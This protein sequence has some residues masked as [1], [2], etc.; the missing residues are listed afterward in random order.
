MIDYDVVYAKAGNIRNC[1]RRIRE[2]THLEADRLVDIDVQDIFVLN[3]QR[4]IQSAI[5]LAAHLVAAEGLG[6]PG[7][8]RENFTLLQRA[9]IITPQIASEMTKMVGFRNIAIHEYQNLDVDVLKS[10]L[11]QHLQD[12]EEFTHH[13]LVHYKL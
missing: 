12:L 13:I 1:L 5:D 9:N 11:T 7:S 3:L 10:I 2:V 6:L 8:I 4:A